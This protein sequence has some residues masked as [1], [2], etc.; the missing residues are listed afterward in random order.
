LTRIEKS[1]EIN[2]SPKKV[3]SMVAW[4]K[5]PEWYD[6]FK[7]VEYTS[8]DKYKVGETVH[9]ISEAAGVKAE[10]DAETT[11]V[12]ENE[13]AAWRSTGGNFT[14]IG[15]TALSPT[16]A[17]TKVTIVMEY[18]LPYSVLGKLIDK[19]RVHKALEKSFDIG[20]KKLKD[21]LEK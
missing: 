19:L 12:I 15:S 7:K 18:E 9:I 1:I 3:W 13:K 5:L 4:E 17:G 21:I 16:K 20:L 8:K 10:W 11:E 14:G 6:L 2:V